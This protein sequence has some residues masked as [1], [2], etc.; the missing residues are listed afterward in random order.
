M[1]LLEEVPT[2]ILLVADEIA[3]LAGEE[4]DCPLN[5]NLRF[6]LADHLNF[7]IQRCRS[8]LSLNTP[9]AYDVKHLYPQEYQL[10]R[11][12]LTL[13]R[14]R[15]DIDLP[16]QEAVNLTLHLI[17]A[18]TEVGDLHSTLITTKII[19][20]LTD[21]VED[22]FSIRLDKDG[23]NYSRFALHLRYLIQRMLQGKP[24]QPEG[25]GEMFRSVCRE[26]PD[27]YACVQRIALYFTDNYGWNCTSDEQLYLMMHLYRLRSSQ[28]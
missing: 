7:A 6:L 14:E 27:I 26:Y 28:S 20:E 18:E 23:F 11:Q 9:L 4:L 24:L 8:G 13:L 25:T 12:V 3:A 17:T 21:L 1:S 19:A 10:G 22:F 5:P 2:E 15:F 16:S